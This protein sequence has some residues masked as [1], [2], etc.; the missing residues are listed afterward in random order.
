MTLTG[1]VAA[2]LSMMGSGAGSVVA[3]ASSCISTSSTEE[4]VMEEIDDPRRINF[5]DDAL[6]Y[7]RNEDS[8]LFKI[9]SSEDDELLKSVVELDNSSDVESDLES[10]E[11]SA[12]DI[13]DS[14]KSM[15]LFVYG[16]AIVMVGEALYRLIHK[17]DYEDFKG[18]VLLYW[19]Q[20]VCMLVAGPLVIFLYE[21]LDIAAIT[22]LTWGFCLSLFLVIINLLDEI[23]DVIKYN[24]M[25][26]KMEKEA[27]DNDQ[28]KGLITDDGSKQN[29]YV[30]KDN[31]QGKGLI[32]DDGSKQNKYVL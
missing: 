5:W 17:A 8:E 28:G 6:V 23:I 20:F 22:L 15:E 14:D 16:F 30:S 27:K 24:R 31:D 7:R 3:L 18:A 19:T 13:T 26:K 11:S 12:C 4:F 29:K 2:G 21:G 10:E 32:T 1:I 25:K 9:E